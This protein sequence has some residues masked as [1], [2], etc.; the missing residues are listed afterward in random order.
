MQSVKAPGPDG[1]PVEF[2][3]KNYSQLSPILLNMFNHSLDQSKLPPSLTQAHI[4]V[5]LKPD[6]DALDC[7]SYRPIS[8]LNVDVKILS[9]VLASRIE[10]IIPDIISQDQT[11][12]IKGRHSF[13]NI[14][15][16]LNVVHS[17]ASESIPEV[18]VSLD[19]EKAFDRVEWNNLFAVLDKFG[20]GSKIISWIHLLYQQPKAAVVTNK[21]A[22]QYFSLSRGT[23]QGCPLSPLL[24]VL[25]IEPLSS[26]LRSSQSIVVLKEGV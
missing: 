23:L 16:L 8:L 9:K 5:L 1:F 3:K 6:K 10:Y 12:F 15:K 21:I 14:R 20:F 18:I 17:P 4:T 19:A 2:Y 22:S 11:G 7:S 25:A 26:V 13:I 24:F